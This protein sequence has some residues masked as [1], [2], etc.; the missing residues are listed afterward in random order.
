MT[1]ASAG[2][3]PRGAQEMNA[4]VV[5]SSTQRSTLLAEVGPTGLS[6][7]EV[8]ARAPASARRP[9]TGDS[10]QGRPGP[11]PPCP[12]WSSPCRTT[13]PASVVER[14]AFLVR[15]W[16]E[17]VS[18]TPNGLVF[19]RALRARQVEP[20]AVRGV[21]RRGHRA[22]SRPVPAG[23]ARR[24]RGRRGQARR[25]PRPDRPRSSSARVSTSTRRAARP[26]P[27]AGDRTRRPCRSNS[28]PRFAR[29]VPGRRSDRGVER[30][31]W[32]G[33]SSGGGGETPA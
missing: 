1:S 19:H 4:P 6:V 24:S 17:Y 14:V 15:H 10:N 30:P 3:G 33:S 29:A 9:S 7:D 27:G 13:C 31:G 22:A 26:R 18:K 11:S 16:W 32:G 28:F 23:A 12:A 2:V 20:S 21:L 25:R 5:R 8:A